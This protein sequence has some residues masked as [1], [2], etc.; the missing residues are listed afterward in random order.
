MQEQ[1][2]KTSVSKIRWPSVRVLRI[3]EDYQYEIMVG[4]ENQKCQKGTQSFSL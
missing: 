3:L 1:G 2:K 4:K